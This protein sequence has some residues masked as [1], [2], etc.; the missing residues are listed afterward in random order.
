MKEYHEPAGRVWNAV[1]CVCVAIIVTGL[2]FAAY[3]AFDF[4]RWL[5]G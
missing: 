4:V 5:V 2:S 1:E 3:M